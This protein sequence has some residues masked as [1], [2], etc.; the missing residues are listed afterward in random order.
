MILRDVFRQIG[1]V[2][3]G[4]VDELRF[5]ATHSAILMRAA[6]QIDHLVE[7]FL[8][9]LQTG[10]R[11]HRATFR[12]TFIFGMQLKMPYDICSYLVAV[13]TDCALYRLAVDRLIRQTVDI[14]RA[15]GQF[16]D[17][18]CWLN[19]RGKSGCLFIGFTFLAFKFFDVALKNNRKGKGGWFFDSSGLNRISFV[20]Q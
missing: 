19:F 17:D 18:L 15:V 20:A 14:P 16:F 11:I 3:R 4:F 8:L 13:R 5:A 7:H 1:L 2:F 12:H 6:G 10:H 9:L